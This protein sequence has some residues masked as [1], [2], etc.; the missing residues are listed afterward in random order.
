MAAV[1]G[2]WENAE[3]S[4]PLQGTNEGSYTGEEER[5]GETI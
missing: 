4:L 3:A 1:D 2:Q 5:P